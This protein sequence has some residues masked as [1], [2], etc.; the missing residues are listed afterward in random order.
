M[1]TLSSISLRHL[2]SEYP[3]TSLSVVATKLCRNREKNEKDIILLKSSFLFFKSAKLPAP[4]NWYR[5]G[6]TNI[7]PR[8]KVMHLVARSTQH[9]AT[10][11]SALRQTSSARAD[12]DEIS[13]S[14]TALQSLASVSN[15]YIIVDTAG[16]FNVRIWQS[17]TKLCPK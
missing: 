6:R 15:S 14:S 10:V 13:V 12:A 8:G 16:V 5:I 4:G 3:S 17:N 11:I 9:T 2:N 1:T 7:L